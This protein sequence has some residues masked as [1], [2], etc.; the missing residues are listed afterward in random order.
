MKLIWKKI[1]RIVYWS[2][3]ILLGYTLT[4]LV[5]KLGEKAKGP[6]DNLADNIE[7]SIFDLES[8]V[9]VK[10]K[11]NSRM[12]KFDSLSQIINNRDKILQQSQLLLGASDKHIKDSYEK[13]FDLEDS[14]NT[15]F[16]LIQIYTAWGSKPEQQFPMLEAK[17]I[18]T[19]GSIPVITWEPWVND[20][21]VKTMG[22]TPEMNNDKNS[23]YNV[24]KGY[25]DSYIRSWAKKAK[26]FG[27]PFY[28]RLGHEMNDPT[29][30][31]WGA[32]KNLSEH[33]IMAWRHV[34]DIFKEEGVNNII[35]VWS[36]HL[37]YPPIKK[38]YPGDEYVDMVGCTVL[39][40]GKAI[41]WSDWWSFEEIFGTH[42]EELSS[43]KKPIMIAEFGSLPEGGDRS[44][45]YKDAIN[46]VYEKYKNVKA[47]IF[48]NYSE[49][50][51]IANRSFNWSIN[52]DKKVIEELKKKIPQKK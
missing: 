27:K 17:T 16:P 34:H 19:L 35:W 6:I 26:V 9:I 43:F 18:S 32:E 50:K 46:L 42:Y 15:T 22:L 49:D 45:W 4:L 48:Y 23:M 51:T 39:N 2:I 41:S 36:P 10:Q 25:Y 7:N 3:A 28:L 12:E 8:K 14:L 11:E 52:D 40:Y 1:D 33:F 20:F 21:D 24:S 37:S 30:Y 5:S 29:R 44:I 38:Y 31:P 47:L 13:I